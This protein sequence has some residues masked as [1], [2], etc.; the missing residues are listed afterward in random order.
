[1]FTA[2]YE[3]YLQM[4]FRFLIFQALIAIIHIVYKQ[5]LFIQF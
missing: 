2:R 4:Y 1:M 5:A 3:M